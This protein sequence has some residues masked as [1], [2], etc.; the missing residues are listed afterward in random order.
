MKVALKDSANLRFFWPVSSDE[1]FMMNSVLGISL[2]FTGE[3]F[4]IDVFI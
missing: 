4:L 3:S 1:V 2:C